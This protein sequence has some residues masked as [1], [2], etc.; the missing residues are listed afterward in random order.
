MQLF[1]Q[2]TSLFCV[3]FTVSVTAG[4]GSKSC[5]VHG[6]CCWQAGSRLLDARQWNGDEA[7]EACSLSVGASGG[8]VWQGQALIA[9]MPRPG[10]GEERV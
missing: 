9:E 3:L 5:A 8:G 6:I 2:N 1:V 4:R 7:G 10:G